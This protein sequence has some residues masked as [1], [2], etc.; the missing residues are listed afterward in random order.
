M[1]LLDFAAEEVIWGWLSH[2]PKS[3]RCVVWD[4]M[5]FILRSPIPTYLLVTTVLCHFKSP[6]FSL[7]GLME[8]I[9][10]ATF[11]SK[12]SANV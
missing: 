1:N 9:N 6:S 5:G 7:P 4:K 2:W 12:I 3:Q 8:E 10:K 11:A